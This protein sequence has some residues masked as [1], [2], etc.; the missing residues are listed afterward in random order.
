MHKD[1]DQEFRCTIAFYYHDYEEWDFLT[2]NL[3]VESKSQLLCVKCGQRPGTEFVHIPNSNWN[4]DEPYV[5]GD[6]IGGYL[7]CQNER[8]KNE[9]R[10]DI[11]R[12]VQSVLNFD[13]ELRLNTTIGS[14]CLCCN[15]IE[16]A[17]H[18]LLQCGRCKKAKFCNKE[19][20]RLAWKKHKLECREPF[21]ADAA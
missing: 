4:D 5:V 17:N 12:N 7:T 10:A 15:K 20:Q 14:R 16:T 13:E 11:Q 6:I 19:C 21:A 2:T 18:R 8:C 1:F 9:I 3:A